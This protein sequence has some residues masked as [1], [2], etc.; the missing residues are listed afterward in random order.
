MCK[1]FLAEVSV[2]AKNQQLHAS[3][4]SFNFG[5]GNIKNN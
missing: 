5:T 2:T 3:E 4:I 1:I